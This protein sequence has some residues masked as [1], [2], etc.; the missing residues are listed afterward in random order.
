MTSSTQT[1]AAQRYHPY[2]F[3]R[4]YA[5]STACELSTLIEQY[6]GLADKESS[7][8]ERRDALVPDALCALG[9]WALKSGDQPAAEDYY[10][11]ALTA[12]EAARAAAADT[13]GQLDNVLLYSECEADALVGQAQLA[14]TRGQFD[15]AEQLLG[16]ALTAAERVS[17]DAHPRLC[18]I[19]TM[20]GNV[21]SRTGRVT[22]AEG[23]YR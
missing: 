21:F 15:A 19:L 11:R 6:G 12:A 4:T 1:P 17:G 2:F 10:S 5:E 22:Y 20:I 16:S 8:P 9:D 23:M 18:P 7:A 14:F 13:P 3:A